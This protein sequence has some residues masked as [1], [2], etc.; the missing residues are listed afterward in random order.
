MALENIAVEIP[1]SDHTIDE[2]RWA[3]L[4]SQLL[5][6]FLHKALTLVAHLKLALIQ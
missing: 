2:G 4:F 1:P 5:L 3:A 6:Y